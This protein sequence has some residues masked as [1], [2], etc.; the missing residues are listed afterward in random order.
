ML[1]QVAAWLF[2]AQCGACDAFGSGLCEACVPFGPPLEAATATLR[3]RALAPYD[4]AMRRAILALKAGRRDVVAA[5]GQRMTALA[6]SGDVLV[7]VPTTFGRRLARGFD[8]SALL[9][10]HAARTAGATVLPLLRQTA[11]DAQRGRGRS[12]R[13]QARGRFG[14][15]AAVTHEV[16][17]LDDVMTT[18]ATLED[19]AATLRAGGAVVRRAIVAAIREQL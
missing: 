10:E 9:A 19:C 13:L 17:L 7:P 18:G 12:A 15:N 14:C 1:E 16:V 2:P 3:V 11:G 5:I 6:G 4:G 8:G